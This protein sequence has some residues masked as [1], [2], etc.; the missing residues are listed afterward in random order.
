VRNAYH[1]P[2]IADR[3]GLGVFVNRC[4]ATANVVL[5]FVEG[6]IEPDEAEQALDAMAVTLGLELQNQLGD[7][8]VES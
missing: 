8:G 7:L 6:A 5:V 3:P 4:G 1:V 2:G